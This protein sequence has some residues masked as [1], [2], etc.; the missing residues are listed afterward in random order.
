MVKGFTEECIKVICFA[1]QESSRLGHNFVGTEQLLLGTIGEGTS[2]VA[3]VLE[4]M[5][6]TLDA[7]RIE[8]EK[9]IGRGSSSLVPTEIPYSPNAIRALEL[10]EEESQQ[11]GHNYF[12]AE[13]ILLGTLR[14]EDG[15][16]LKV[17]ANLGLDSTEIREL[18]VRMLG[19]NTKVRDEVRE[20]PSA[21]IRDYLEVLRKLRSIRGVENREIVKCV[22]STSLDKLLNEWENSEG[23]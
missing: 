17:L 4:S 7:T 15:N 20:N 18:V 16:A 5:G 11:L 22:C 3:K 14:I 13:H 21:L 6:V 19:E 23:V 8:V 1:Q 2:I 10:V 9:I 12:R